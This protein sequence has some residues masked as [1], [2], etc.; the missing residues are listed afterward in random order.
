MPRIVGVGRA[1]EMILTGDPVTAERAETMGLVNRVVPLAALMETA[2][3]LARQL[4][5]LPPLAIQY[6]KEAVYRGLDAVPEQALAHESYLHAL[7]CTS[8]DKKEGVAAFL[9]KRKPEFKGR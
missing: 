1:L 5:A 4:A 8:E 9:G 6:A 7:S 2:T 3:D